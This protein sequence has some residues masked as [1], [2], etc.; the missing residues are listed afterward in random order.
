M[1]RQHIKNG[2]FFVAACVV[3]AIALFLISRCSRNTGNPDKLDGNEIAVASPDYSKICASEATY[4]LI[5]QELFRLAAQE[6]GS[7]E[8]VYAK[9]AE[10]SV[11]RVTRPLFVESD[12]TSGRIACSGS[13]AVAFPP[14]LT[15]NEG[16]K[17]VGGDLEYFVQPAAD[18]SGNAITL[19]GSDEIVAMLATLQKANLA[20]S[21]SSPFG[22][23][24]E[25]PQSP[26]TSN[27]ES[28][29]EGNRSQASSI[30]PNSTPEGSA[31]SSGLSFS[32]QS[33]RTGS[34]T[35]V[36]S[37]PS[38]ALLDRQM[39]AFYNRSIAAADESQ[40]QVLR[41][42]RSRFLG[43][44]ERCGSDVACIDR[45][46]RG[47]ITEIGDIIAGRWQGSR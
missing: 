7:D 21:P 20:D 5:K 8:A 22:S 36:C 3:I 4:R 15:D 31:V 27:E 39:A 29:P 17:S 42:T 44:R 2:L 34:E 25:V 47:R 40:A 1:E 46:Y 35:A 6:R 32:C 14:N 30:A 11:V 12:A 45:T 33:A 18:G 10:F 16:R 28:A 43:Y 13:V 19:G 24:V 41:E 9:I 26:K 23:E 37:S 38:L